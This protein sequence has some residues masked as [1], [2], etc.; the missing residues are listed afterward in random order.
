MLSK[1]V[2]V[3]LIACGVLLAGT[4]AF[5]EPAKTQD[6]QAKIEERMR[7]VVARV[8]RQE[9]GLDDTRAKTVEQSFDQFAPE[10]RRVRQELARFRK[11]L[12]ELLEK[13]SNDQNAYKQA[14]EGFRAAQKKLQQVRERELEALGKQL[15]PKEQ[16]KFTDA[17]RK[18]NKK[19]KAALRDFE[20]Q[21]AT[22]P[23]QPG[24]G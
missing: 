22:Q 20:D 12:S 15:T 14:L 9:C 1:Q 19:L 2:R 24:P 17:M 11:M 10:R 4:P 23:T 16:A 13:D 3:V 6:K 5:A 21:Q 18:L 7:S 8:L